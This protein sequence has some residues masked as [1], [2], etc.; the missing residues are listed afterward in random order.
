M[1]HPS[2]LLTWL[3]DHPLCYP[4][5]VGAILAGA[6][7][8]ALRAWF[9]PAETPAPQSDW[10]W[11]LVLLA[12]LAAGRW[13]SMLIPAQLNPD[14][15]QFLAGA[16]TLAHDPVFWRSVDG[17][18]SGPLN[19]L[20]LWPAG[21]LAGW[22]SYLGARLTALGLLAAAFTLLHQSL[23]IACRSHAMRLATLAA[24]TG[25]TLT[26]SVDLLHYSS[27]LLSVAWLGVAAYAAT[28]R[29]VAA[30]GPGWCALG[31]LAL[32]AIP[33]SKLQP[34][35]LALV[36]GLAWVVAEIISFRT[37]RSRHLV[38]LLAG[39]IL[40]SALFIGQVILAGEWANF[41]TSYF[42]ANLKYTAGQG[43]IGHQHETWL[44][45]SQQ[46]DSLLH[47]WLPGMLLWCVLALRPISDRTTRFVTIGAA[48]ALGVSVFCVLS[49][50]RPF[51]HYWQLALPALTLLLGALLAN[52]RTRPARA[53]RWLAAVC[54]LVLIGGL[55]SHRLAKPNFFMGAFTY[56]E[57]HPRQ[58]VSAR[59]LA[60]AQPGEALA[61]WGWAT[62]LYVETGLRQATRNADCAQVIAP[63]GLQ[64]FFRYRY[65][66][67][68]MVNR[69]A[70]FVDAVGPA[71]IYFQSPALKHD[72]NFPELGAVI[73]HDYVLVDEIDGTQI[74][75]R[76]DL[77]AGARAPK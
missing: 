56:F 74:Y 65:L 17:T 38:Y 48:V 24:V 7:A 32:G 1:N 13:P 4:W 9:R 41:T 46:E 22:D 10:T 29:W 39:A 18:T 26:N 59:V 37:N 42:L 60:Q 5:F 49:P 53:E 30:G 50:G 58:P 72:R 14:E 12:V 62:Q 40:P 34:V 66:A 8:L 76:R 19:F 3:D 33:M 6:L 63:G 25:L 21:W 51:L 70:T 43:F 52:L 57:A 71:S 27:E 20:V 47:L 45:K 23:A 31:G 68:L 67:D 2:P 11:G 28:R 75:R 55:W 54:A 15:S 44:T 35:P 36:A 16:H 61:V 73:R 69:P 77:V 64:E